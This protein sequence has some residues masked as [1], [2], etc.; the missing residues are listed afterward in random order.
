[1]QVFHAVDSTTGFF[2]TSAGGTGGQQPVLCPPG[3]YSASV[4]LTLVGSSSAYLSVAVSVSCNGCQVCSQAILS[5]CSEC[6]FLLPLMSPPRLTTNLL[7]LKLSFSRIG[8]SVQDKWVRR[9]CGHRSWFFANYELVMPIL[10]GTTI[11]RPL[12]LSKWACRKLRA[13]DIHC[14]PI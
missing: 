5:A 6:V 7:K 8:G 2:A 13:R 1:M 3:G 10:P 14:N 9:G 4:L 11:S 12:M